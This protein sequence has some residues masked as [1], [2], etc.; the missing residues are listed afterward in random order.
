[1]FETNYLESNSNKNRA[2]D[3]RPS[4][5]SFALIKRAQEAVND[6]DMN[7]PFTVKIFESWMAEYNIRKEDGT[8]YK[9]G[10]VAT[11]LSNS[12]VMK[13]NTTSRNSLWLD[14]RMNQD[15]VFEYWFV[16]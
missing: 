3:N 5:M 9:D 10:Y 8:K 15:G 2:P 7:E 11:L 14:R 12:Y 4:D 6:G 1:M 13:K 16:T